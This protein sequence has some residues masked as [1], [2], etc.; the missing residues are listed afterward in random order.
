[1]TNEYQD[2]IPYVKKI[3]QWVKVNDLLEFGLGDGT[4]FFLE[5]CKTVTSIEISGCKHSN[6]DWY[7]K[8]IEKY[9][10][11]KNW[12]P[13]YIEGSDKMRKAD[14]RA[15][16][17]PEN[18]YHEHIPYLIEIIEPLRYRDMIFV[19]STH[20]RGDILNILFELDKAD[21]IAAHDTS[22]FKERCVRVYGYDRLIIP[23]NFFEVHFENDTAGTTFWIK[24][25]K[26][27]V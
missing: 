24:E 4:E 22:R 1:M 9:K 11:Y 8:C 21:I 3:F 20:T 14:W 15:R 6:G 18:P 5:N 12:E 13:I 2:W 7:D 26:L 25:N 17:Y 27:C 16:R 23:K 10:Q 19:D